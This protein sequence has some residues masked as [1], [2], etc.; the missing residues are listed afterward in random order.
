MGAGGAVL[1]HDNKFNRWAAGRGA[2][3]F[4]NEDGCAAALDQ[5]LAAPPEMLDAMREAS[6]ARHEEAFLWQDI[7]AQYETLLLHWW[8]RV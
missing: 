7:L 4:A 3:Y 8:Q 5:L 6:R 2:V 1:A